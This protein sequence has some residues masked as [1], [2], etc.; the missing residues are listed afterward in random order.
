MSA[1]DWKE[2]FLAACE[3]HIELVRYHVK[4]KVDLNYAHP[5]FL[6]TPLVACILARQA[7]VADLLLDHGADPLLLSEFEGLTPV[8]AARQA[9]LAELEARLRAMGAADP[10]VPSR[11]RGG[12]FAPFLGR[13]LWWA[14]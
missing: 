11:S 1:G 5:E 10:A 7:A 4:N 2:L 8:Q 9:G 13:W 14:R 3:G 6:S 12:R